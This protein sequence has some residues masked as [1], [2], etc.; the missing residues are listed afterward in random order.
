MNT[1]Y[2]ELK[3]PNQVLHLRSLF[4]LGLHSKAPVAWTLQLQLLSPSLVLVLSTLPGT[5]GQSENQLLFFTKQIEQL[6]DIFHI[7]VKLY[8]HHFIKVDTK[9]SVHGNRKTKRIVEW[10]YWD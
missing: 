10:Y 4:A 7:T 8:L 5:K 3:K 1:R 2:L 6:K 9:S